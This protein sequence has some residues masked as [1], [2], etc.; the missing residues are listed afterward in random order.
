MTLMLKNLSTPVIDYSPDNLQW[1]QRDPDR[2]TQCGLKW[3][4]INTTNGIDEE[5]E[6]KD[7]IQLNGLHRLINTFNGISPGPT[8]VVPLGAEVVIRIKNRMHSKSFTVHVHGVDKINRWWTDGVPFI[9]QCPISPNTDYSYRFIADTPGTH[10][11]HGHLMEDSGEGLVGGF[12][13]LSTADPSQLYLDRLHWRRKWIG[14]SLDNEKELPDGTG[15]E[16]VERTFDGTLSREIPVS[17]IIIG[18][19][20]WHNQTDII[21]R[22][23]RL[24]LTTFGI[25]IGENIMLRLVNAGISQGVF[26][27]IED[28]DFWIVAAD[29]SYIKPIKV[30]S[31]LMFSGERYDIIIKGLAN[32]KRKIYR[33]IFELMEQMK[34][35]EG[36]IW[37]NRKPTV[38][39]ANILYENL[40][41]EKENN[42]DQVDWTHNHCTENKKCLVFNCPF[43]QFPSSFNM[44]CIYSDKLQGEKTTNNNEHLLEIKN[45]TKNVSKEEIKEKEI[46]NEAIKLAL[47]SPKENKK[48]K[49]REIF[50]NLH[51]GLN[52]WRFLDPKGI[53][54][55]RKIDKVEEKECDEKKCDRWANDVLYNKNCQCFINYKFNLGEIIQ[56]IA[57]SAGGMPHPFH[58]HGHK[59]V[60]LRMGFAE[61]FNGNGTLKGLNKHLEC[62]GKS[63]RCAEMK[64]SN[65]NWEEGEIPEIN[66]NPVLRDTVV[67]P[68]KGFVVI[69]FRANNPGW[70]FAHCHLLMHSMDGMNF[71]FRVG[72]DKEIP[73]PPKGFP[74]HCGI[75]EE[76]PISKEGSDHLDEIDED[77]DKMSKKQKLS[78]NKGIVIGLETSKIIMLFVGILV[79]IYVYL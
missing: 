16:R 29:G 57:V 21:N 47:F 79:N 32:P 10:W 6:L 72:K 36:G 1:Y 55:F 60:V 24:P 68:A 37:K 35:M 39:L 74:H 54:Y 38:G 52:G 76:L 70:W 33:I 19:K 14:H 20:G 78:C 34:E 53:P 15:C 44:S 12:V 11:Y 8:I 26:V 75:Y 41:V 40:K 45:Q 58:L 4:F 17:A 28:H 51:D 69:R 63:N 77:D 22:P 62:L 30:D 5:K 31:L 48:Q 73:S 56:I 67:V 71:A 49:F 46:I 23:S 2:G 13:D 18:N 25:E 50:V 9:Q 64:W 59:F 66:K 61:Q 27:W 7:L 65:K 3:A 43:K 42:N